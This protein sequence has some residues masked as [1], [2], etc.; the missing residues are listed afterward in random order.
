MTCNAV[1]RDFAI[2]GLRFFTDDRS[3]AVT[4]TQV[5][6][7]FPILINGNRRLDDFENDSSVSPKVCVTARISEGDLFRVN[8]W[9]PRRLLALRYVESVL[10]ILDA[11][12]T[13]STKK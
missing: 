6:R 5:F 4:V 13:V 11:V 8:P 7:P 2:V 1:S 12:D 3:F 10:F 9:N